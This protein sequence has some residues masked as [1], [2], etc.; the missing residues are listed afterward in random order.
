MQDKQS[1]SNNTND[2]TIHEYKICAGK[3]CNNIG[4]NRLNILF[5]NKF[6]WFCDCCKED[7]LSSKLIQEG[8]ECFNQNY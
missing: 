7:L 6:G 3:G 2:N 1:S 8:D 4:E 5:I